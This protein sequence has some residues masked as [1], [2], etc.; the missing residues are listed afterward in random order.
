MHPSAQ[1]V[2]VNTITVGN[3]EII[4]VEESHGPVGLTAEQYIPGVPQEVWRRHESW[5]APDHLDLDSRLAQV[6]MQSWVLRSQGRTIVVDTGVGND[7]VR[8]AVPV[9]DRVD[10][11]TYLTNMHAAGV[12]PQD[13]DLVVN[14]HLHVDHVGWNTRLENGEWAP[15]F[16]N[17]TYLMPRVEFEYWNPANNPDVAGGVNENVYDDSVAPVH[18]AGQVRL[19]EGEHRIDADLVLE[20]APGHTPGSSV[21]KVVSGSE[22][23]LL[24]GDLVHNPVQIPES[25]YNSCFCEDQAAARATRRSLLGWA[26]EHHALVLPAHFSGAGAVTVETSGADFAIAAWAPFA[27]L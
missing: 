7:K 24:A 15:T 11:D 6:G 25:D 2:A 16:P 27:A 18:A 13:V 3:V 19:W 21:L 22:R 8:P 23:A 10:S 14:T 17:A 26:A 9:W 5:L 1:V 12:R 20:A 4:R